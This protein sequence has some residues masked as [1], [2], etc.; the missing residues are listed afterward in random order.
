MDIH[1]VITPT[2]TL[3]ESA[4]ALPPCPRTLLTG[5]LR[6]T[7]NCS[8]TTRA[9]GQQSLLLGVNGQ[10]YAEGLGLLS[11]TC[12]QL[13]QHVVSCTSCRE[14]VGLRA[15]RQRLKDL[16]STFNDLNTLQ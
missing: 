4:R 1:G 7:E 5:Q 3:G 14:R 2:L 11:N 10:H 6:L 16:Q 8:T 13:R 15:G 9:R 12:L